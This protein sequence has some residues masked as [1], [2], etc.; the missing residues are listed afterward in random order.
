[1]TFILLEM[2]KIMASAS[3]VSIGNELLIGH[4]TD[5]NAT[6]ICQRLLSVGVPVLSVYTVGDD[7]GQ[8]VRALKRATEDA[9]FVI[10]TGGLGPTDD[11]VTRQAFASFL[12]VELVF[13]EKL[14]EHIRCFFERRDIKMA[15]NNKVQAY[16]PA[17][18][19]SIANRMGTAPGIWAET[20][21]QEHKCISAQDTRA[22]DIRAQDTDS[23][24][25]G[26]IL[27][28]LPGVPSEMK[29]MFETLV[30]PRLKGLAQG[31]VEVVKK[32]K[33]FGTGES[34][35]AATLGELM[36][37]GRNPLVN[38]TVDCGVVTLHVVAAGKDRKQA[39]ELADKYVGIVRDRL[40]KIVFG[41]EDQ[42]L[43]EV[44]G[45]MLTE[46]NKTLVVAESCT[47]GTIAKLIT[48]N[49]GASA[50]FT[51]G[52]ITYSNAAKIN[53]LG[54]PK[55]LIEKY[56]AVSEE[57]A[58]AMAISAREKAGTDF[59]IATTGIAG[60]TGGSEQKPVGLVYISINSN[61]GCRTERFIFSHSR[62]SIR[63]RAALTAL[64]MLRLKLGN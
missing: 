49:P 55:E 23:A 8:I 31:Q 53:G 17:G 46:Q 12:N 44:V 19:E 9:C 36:Q 24:T 30:L 43:A 39:E 1:M 63:L 20:S 61:D 22:Q 5:T 47:G 57:A 13:H 51:H 21:A 56:G 58:S 4:T 2:F 11:D 60:P 42:T 35:I 37:R 52:W 38:S 28:A 32:L 29:E 45:L 50:Y 40:G 33:C 6:F 3:I 48:D 41:T 27:I 34:N 59:A 14:L 18:A 7:I 10:A 54:V 26:K 64:N 16:L 15:Q 25:E 62:Q